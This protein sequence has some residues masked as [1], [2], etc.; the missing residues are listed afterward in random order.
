MNSICDQVNGN[1]NLSKLAE[2]WNE[3]A[4]TYKSLTS[5]AKSLVTKL[6]SINVQEYK[7]NIEAMLSSYKY[8]VN[9]YSSLEAFISGYKI[10]N[11]NFVVKQ[12]KY[13][14]EY[15]WLLISFSILFVSLLVIYLAIRKNKFKK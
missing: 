1:T 6:D 4:S 10:S 2:K 11:S 15:I 12:F 13:R 7:N 8:I 9:K 14:G 5:G 3:L